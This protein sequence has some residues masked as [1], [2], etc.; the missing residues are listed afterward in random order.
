MKSLTLHVSVNW[1]LRRCLSTLEQG[2][3]DNR[4]EFKDS[5]PL[6]PVSTWDN[7]PPSLDPQLAGQG[8]LSSKSDTSSPAHGAL[9]TGLTEV[10]R[11][12][13][14]I[15]DN[16]VPHKQASSGTSH[17]TSIQHPIRQDLYLSTC[18]IPTRH[19]TASFSEI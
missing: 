3:N 5:C 18:E 10:T 2:L 8:P 12:T 14:E 9:I 15:P 4:T 1:H 11:E 16:C 6:K 7:P 13:P 19:L 17:P